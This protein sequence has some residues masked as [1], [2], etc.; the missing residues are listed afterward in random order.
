M[1]QST[2]TSGLPQVYAG[3]LAKSLKFSREN[4]AFL[5]SLKKK[6][7]KKLDDVFHHLHQQAFEKI[8][9]LQCANCCKTTSPIFYDK[10]IERLSRHLR[11]RPAKFIKQYLKLDQE[12]D[13]VLIQSPCAF[14][15]N[16]NYCGVYEARPTACRQYPHTDRK[17]MHQILDLT[18]HNTLVCPAVSDIVESLKKVC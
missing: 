14:L 16:D 13:Y 6:P 11:L 5:S 2:S 12:G 1:S 18:Y 4:K 3:K 8:N 7:P 15:S 9:C 10:D 17:R